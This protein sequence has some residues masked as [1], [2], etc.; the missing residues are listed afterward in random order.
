MLKTDVRTANDMAGGQTAGPAGLLP[1]TRQDPETIEHCVVPQALPAFW[2]GLTTG[3]LTTGRLTTGRLTTRRP[4]APVWFHVLK[5][6]APQAA[7]S[8]D[9]PAARD[10][11]LVHL[12]LKY[13]GTLKNG[14]CVPAEHPQK[15][16]SHTGRHSV[17]MPSVVQPAQD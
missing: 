2:A 9:V 15:P 16:A 8:T 12:L 11:S 6:A 7:A 17:N 13:D 1:H 10:S 5:W 14:M 4:G 3:R